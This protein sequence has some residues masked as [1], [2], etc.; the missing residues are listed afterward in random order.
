MDITVRA[1][2]RL[3]KT[4]AK[5]KAEQYCVYQERAQEEVRNK[6]YQWGLY[7]NEVEE[8]IAE[9]IM[10]NFLNEERFAMAYVSGK[11][12]MKGWGRIKIKQGLKQKQVSPRLI[13]EAIQAIDAADYHTTLLSILEKKASVLKEANPL[14][15]KQKLLQHAMLKGYENDLVFDILNNKEL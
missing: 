12:K 3:S 13:K 14:K 1:K 11:F 8:V 15:R 9:L 2:Q 10:D 4:A 5:Q 7:P 6:L